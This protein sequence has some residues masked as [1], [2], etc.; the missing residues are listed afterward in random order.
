MK[1]ASCKDKVKMKIYPCCP[2]ALVAHVPLVALVA[3]VALVAL[4]A[5]FPM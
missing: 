4:V 1:D 5:L 3:H 2:V